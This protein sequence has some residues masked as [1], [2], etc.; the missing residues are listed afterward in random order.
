[1]KNCGNCF[2]CFTLEDEKET[3]SQMIISGIYEDDEK[4]MPHGGDC[5]LEIENKNFPTA[6][7]QYRDLEDGLNYEEERIFGQLVLGNISNDEFIK[8]IKR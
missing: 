2:W 5:S 8:K 4:N 3:R 1:M 7:E 6:C